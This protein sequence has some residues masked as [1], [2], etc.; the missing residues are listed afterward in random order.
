[1]CSGLSYAQGRETHA[2]G[3]AQLVG[4]P[5]G[6]PCGIQTPSG[7]AWY[8]SGHPELTTCYK[9]GVTN[10]PTQDVNHP[11]PQ[12]LAYVAV[13]QVDAGFSSRGTI[14]LHS[15]DGGTGFL[16]AGDGTPYVQAY[17]QAHFTTVQVAWTDDWDDNTAP[18]P[19]P[20]KSVKDE[21]CRPATLL[22]FIHDNYAVPATGAMCAQGH[23]GGASA[24]G[25][26][27]E[28]YGA[29][30]AANTTQNGNGYLDTVVMTSGPTLADI[31]NGCH[32]LAPPHP[33]TSS[34]CH[35]GVC[36]GSA[37]EWQSCLQHPMSGQLDCFGGGRKY[38]AGDGNY[39]TARAVAMH[40]IDLN[41]N[42]NNW[43]GSG[44]DT[45]AIDP[46]WLDMSLVPAPFHQYP[47][48][49]VYGFLC[50]GPNYNENLD[51]TS[52]SSAAQGWS[53]LST[54]SVSSG[55]P[56]A[57]PQIYRVDGCADPEMIWA[58]GSTAVGGTSGYATS[59]GAMENNCFVH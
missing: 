48:T 25:Y 50:S 3:N 7:D 18:D 41:A 20:V 6:A 24:L 40:T 42:C 1:M 31:Y 14:V 32:Y 17:H 36:V 44:V 34:V 27:M 29:D 9:V 33:V 52:N 11:V 54:L 4:Q 30:R 38:P 12:L 47:Q 16:N 53:Y 49:F 22:K 19:P 57:F 8:P 21:A 56:N 35:G 51:D 45:T 59:E 55:Q 46:D 13:T 58:H 23:S 39:A 37:T 26:A 2:L 5:K 43:K 15:G 10:C 28:F